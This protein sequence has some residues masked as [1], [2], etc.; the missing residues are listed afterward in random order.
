L[1]GMRFLY[2]IVYDTG[3]TAT[4]DGRQRPERLLS[5]DANFRSSSGVL[6]TVKTRRDRG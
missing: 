3:W 2:F 6:Q 1:A 4:G 5:S